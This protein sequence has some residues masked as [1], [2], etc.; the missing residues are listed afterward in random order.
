VL[1]ANN[2]QACGCMLSMKDKCLYRETG[3]PYIKSYNGGADTSSEGLQNG[4][5]HAFII[6]FENNDDRDYCVHHDTMHQDLVKSFDSILGKAQVVDFSHGFSDCSCTE[7]RASDK[8][9]P[10][11]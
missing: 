10:R 4:F 7:L 6:E 9:I 1:K 2:P 5:T 8:Y 11:I 3:K